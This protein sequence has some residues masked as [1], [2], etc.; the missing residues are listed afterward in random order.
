MEVD[1][2]GSGVH[3]RGEEMEL[4]S[5]EAVKYVWHGA[6]PL[7]IHLHESEVTTLPPP[8]PILIL[9][10]RLGYL[11]LLIPLI[12]PYFND[13]LPPGADTFWFDYKGLPLKWYIPT[14][15]L[16]DLLCA[17]PERPWNLT[18]H[19]RGHP[20]EILT[21]CDGEDPVKW[22]FINSLK[23]AA[24]IVNGN[25]KNIMNMSQTDQS[26]LWQ[27]LAKGNVE[28]YNRVSS[29]LKLGPFG[30][31]VTLKMGQGSPQSGQV[32]SGNESTW[33]YKVPVRLYLRIIGDVNDIEDATAIVNWDSVFHVNR[34][35][36]IHKQEG[37]YIT[38]KSAIKILL[39]E[40]FDDE[41][42]ASVC[43]HVLV[44]RED[45][46]VEAGLQEAETT[47][48]TAAKMAILEDQNCTDFLGLKA[49]SPRPSKI[50][51]IRIQGI[52]VDLD[53]P[54][55]W[56]VNNLRNPEYFLH[57]CVYIGAS[58]KSA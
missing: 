23:E 39:P 33:A 17:E 43:D 51:L 16:F 26:E 4:H 24:Y 54:F 18:V 49:E 29:R 11:P 32:N 8:P 55:L 13:S 38:F 12:K 58:S 19:F 20:G 50:K 56:V 37:Q 35:I 30:E 15:V 2:R 57:I 53:I 46:E 36:E 14:G 41:D 21:P 10:P 22:S 7:Q 48:S 34:P 9:G 44:T 31:D 28:G 25:C 1:R 6:I 47:A 3:L 27:S 42:E 40:F 52:E 45:N 5:K